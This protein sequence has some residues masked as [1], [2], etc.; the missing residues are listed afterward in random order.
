MGC[1]P[2]PPWSSATGPLPAPLL[3]LCPSQ[4]ELSRWLYHLEK[5]MALVGG[6]PCLHLAPPQGPAE[7]EPSWSLQPRLTHLQ[8][9]WGRQMVGSAIC[10]SRVKLQHLPS[11]VGEGH[12]VR[13]EEGAEAAGGAALNAHHWGPH[14]AL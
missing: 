1:Q 14:A 13:G 2:S 3:V 4:A 6:L 10:A 9:A 12:G 7:D 8:T 5:Q 11:Q